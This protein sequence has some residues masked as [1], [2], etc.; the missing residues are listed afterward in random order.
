MKPVLRFSA[1]LAVSLL[2]QVS[3]PG[4]GST[5]GSPNPSQSTPARAAAH[6]LSENTV[7]VPGPL[8]S[9]LRMTGISQ[10]VS[11]GDVL[12]LLARNAYAS[13]YRAGAPTEYLRL[14]DRYLHQA[15]ELQMLAGANETIRVTNCADAEP[16][17]AHPRLPCAT[18]L[19]PERLG[20]FHR[21]PGA[22]IPHHRFGFP[23][24]QRWKKRW[25]TV[26]PSPTPIPVRTFP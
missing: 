23:A 20:S 22:S 21:G 25:K 4:S 11:T 14:I 3:V 1:V 6:T 10:Q 7:V 16:L 5:R 13:G 15:R 12:P 8:R 9:F 18:D 2:C 24:H 26:R 17:A 19:R